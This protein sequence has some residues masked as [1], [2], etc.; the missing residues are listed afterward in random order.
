MGTIRDVAALAGVSISTVS[1]ALTS[2]DRVSKETRAKVIAAAQAVDYVPNTLAPSLRNGATR[3]IGVITLDLTNPFTSTMLHAI[4]RRAAA[5]NYT[6]V[7]VSS[8]SDPERELVA[9]NLLKSQR[10]AGVLLN[11]MGR[12]PEHIR[13]IERISMPLVLFDQ[14]IS[15][16]LDFVGVDNEL[17]S[18]ML[19]EYLLR[20]G[21]RRIAFICGQSGLWTAD[22]RL[23][24]F[25]DTL[26]QHGIPH[27]PSL[28]LAGDYSG[29][30]AY[31]ITVDL[32]SHGTPPTAILAANNVMALGALEAILALGFRCPQDISLA[33]IDDVPWGT[34]VKPRLTTVTQPIEDLANTATEWLLEQIAHGPQPHT[35]QHLVLPPRLVLGE[36][37]AD[38]RERAD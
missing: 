36:S 13:K 29:D 26:E 35:P 14:Q 31:Q 19:T 20:L 25:L 4:E 18:R 9:L 27:D 8:D 33:G 6:M 23:K 28:C 21:H 1:L 3:H 34:L 32:L 24:G 12:D 11:S 5:A 7:V 10:V 30:S 17:S 2:T 16:K 22:M 15:Q 38:I 37:C